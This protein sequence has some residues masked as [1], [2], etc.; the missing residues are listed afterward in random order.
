[1]SDGWERLRRATR[2][3]IGLGRSGEAVA[4]RDVLAFQ[5][6]HAQARDAVH[7]AL[8]P[9]ALSEALSDDPGP[10][11]PLLLHSAA[12]DRGTY[13]RRPDLGRRLAAESAAA[14]PRGEWD[15]AFI[16]G[17]GLS[18]TAVQRHA[19]PVLQ[20][21]RRRLH[22]LRLAP[23]VIALQAR[24]ALGD[25][26]GARLGA[27]LAVMLIGE[28]PG[29]SVADSLGAYLTFGPRPGRADSERNC[30]SNIHGAGGLSHAGAADRIA[31]LARQALTLGLTGVAL[32]ED[33]QPALPD[34][35]A[36]LS[37]PG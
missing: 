16:I 9:G 25:E 1:M 3:R 28:R 31:W 23:P 12:P 24:V 11:V 10:G 15:I 36:T 35:S 34:V 27:R 5:M 26:I 18:A 14:I 7:A 17:D 8:D 2:A 32:K 21:A 20:A 22:G 37:P 30:V 29:L 33:M 13:L 19:A 4:I 6:A